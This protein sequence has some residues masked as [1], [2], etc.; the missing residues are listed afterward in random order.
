MDDRRSN[1]EEWKQIGFLF[2]QTKRQNG[3]T[4]ISSLQHQRIGQDANQIFEDG[5]VQYI[6]KIVQCIRKIIS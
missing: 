4:I 1:V 3:V 5:V 6:Q 2:N